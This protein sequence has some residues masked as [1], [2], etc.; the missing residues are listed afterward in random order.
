MEF[1]YRTKEERLA[2]VRAY[3]SLPMRGNQR[4]NFLKRNKIIT[5]TMYAWKYFN[6]EALGFTG[7]K[8]SK[9]RSNVVWNRPTR[10]LG[11]TLKAILNEAR[12]SKDI[13][14]QSKMFISLK[15]IGF[16]NN[17]VVK[18]VST[19]P[20]Q[21]EFEKIM[22]AVALLSEQYTIERKEYA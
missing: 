15:D 14:A 22:S 7:K 21:E 2:L 6:K 13:L 9:K 16:D 1:I 8:E 12:D 19:L 4:K 5:S 10:L 18:E 17:L 20:S 11:K 3:Y